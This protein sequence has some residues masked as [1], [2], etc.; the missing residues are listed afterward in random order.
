[1]DQLIKIGFAMGA[2]TCAPLLAQEKVIADFESESS[3]LK[4][5]NVNDGVMG[6]LSKGGARLTEGGNLYFKGDISLRNNGGFSST[7]SYG[8]NF[9]LSDYK[10]VEIRVKGDGRKY[11]FPSRAD[12]KRMLAF[13]SPVE[14]KDGEWMTVRIPFSDFYATSFGRKIPKL[15]LNT[16]NITSFG[17]ML[18]DKRDGKFSIELDYIKVYK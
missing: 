17:L 2:I 6:G 1:M 18:Y 8:E 5:Q 16:K 14:T 12:N 13:W 10:G 4:W 3:S 15:T 9:D 7:R 11:Y